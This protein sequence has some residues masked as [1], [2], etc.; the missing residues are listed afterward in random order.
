MA[1][2]VR[3][4]T[5]PSGRVF[6]VAR[7]RSDGVLNPEE[8]EYCARCNIPIG[9]D[10]AQLGWVTLLGEDDLPAR[11]APAASPA[12][13]SV[14]TGQD[15]GT[16]AHVLTT[17]ITQ[18]RE[19]FDAIA[20]PIV[21]QVKAGMLSPAD[22]EQRLWAGVDLSLADVPFVA[23]I[24]RY[25][26]CYTVLRSLAAR[27]IGQFRGPTIP[28]EPEHAAASRFT[29][30]AWRPA[31]VESYRRFLDN[32]KLWAFMYE[33]YPSPFTEETARLLIEASQV[34]SHHEVLAAEVDGVTIGQVRL[35][36]D[37]SYP[38]LQTAEVSYWIGEEHWGKAFG[39]KI[40]Q[41]YTHQSF[42]GRPLDLIYAWIRT[43]H[44]ASIKTAERAGYRRDP[45]PRMSSFASEVRRAGWGRWICHRSDCVATAAAVAAVSTPPP[46][47][48]QKAERQ[49]IS[50]A[51]GR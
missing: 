31:D 34:A 18:S 50:R 10:P 42:R 21:E 3:C 38:G 23:D 20:R 1:T 4:V 48:P 40:L 36:F 27:T 41:V 35:L 30:R 12:S 17:L 6:D 13:V 33:E 2:T 11:H 46:R 22:A 29:F 44:A 39:A 14:S 9:Y 5:L 25:E 26:K 37:D 7:A 51:G 47:E 45:F 8:L 43:E 24:T 19:R 16:D 15:A 32:P 28:A 49:K